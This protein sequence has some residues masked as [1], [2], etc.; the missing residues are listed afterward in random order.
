MVSSVLQ[1]HLKLPHFP[2]SVTGYLRLQWELK[3]HKSLNYY[4]NWSFSPFI[5]MTSE[6]FQDLFLL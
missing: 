6:H 3:I 5:R 1:E 2:N 4:R